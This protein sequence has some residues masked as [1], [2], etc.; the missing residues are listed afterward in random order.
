MKKIRV[1]DTRRSFFLKG[2]AAIGAGLVS[3]SAGAA[4]L[5]A[6]S[7]TLQQQLD[8]LQK[9]LSTLEE[10]EALK[11]LYLVFT[12]LLENQAYDAV[13]EL[14]A[15][16]AIVNLHGVSLAGKA[17]VK[18]L[19]MEDYEEQKISSLHSAH[20]QDQSQK[21]DQISVSV[22]GNHG[23]ARFHS[24]VLVRSPIRGQSVLAD[25]AR[26]QGMTAQSH[27]E[28]G[29]YDIAFARIN[30]RWRICRLGYHR[31]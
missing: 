21:R 28:N 17:A 27:W 3:A 4:T 24:Q 14:F 6:S 13:V 26:Q 11:H 30:D 10:K 15:D 23:S 16:D 19:F 12:G 1:N 7:Q 5:F 29:R 2:T 8:Q 22:D 31:I 25:M 9:K 20:R 18:K